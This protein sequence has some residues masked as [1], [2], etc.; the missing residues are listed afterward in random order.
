MNDSLCSGDLGGMLSVVDT[1]RDDDPG[2]LLP[3][4]V[5][6]GLGRLIPA[7]EVSFAALDV[8]NQR[9]EIQQAV[10][11]GTERC[12]EVAPA[13]HPDG[14]ASYWQHQESFWASAPF[15]QGGRVGR[16]SDSRS[17]PSS[18][19]RRSSRGE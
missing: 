1:A 12:I 6:V 7:E 10:L 18:S 13:D 19:P 14:D 17:T 4:A 11:D 15:G 3:W 5:L 16:W 9:R 2:P 8:V